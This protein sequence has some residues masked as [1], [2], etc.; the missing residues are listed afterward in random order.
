MSN[1]HHLA[2]LFFLLLLTLSSGFAQTENRKL[3]VNPPKRVRQFNPSF[4]GK[5]EQKLELVEHKLSDA[6]SNY[7]VK[8]LNELLADGLD[9]MGL[10]TPNAKKS[11]I[12]IA[13]ASER[14]KNEYRV[15]AVEKTDIRIHLMENIGIVIGRIEIDYKTEKGGGSA[16]ANFMNV[17]SKDKNGEWRC[18]SMSTDGQKLIH[19]P[20]I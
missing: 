1:K 9:V 16:V 7:D 3:V 19:Y 10:I 13:T 15:L 12:D 14:F 18:I 6:F 17:W 2:L 8:V 5:P 4:A 20:S 11:I